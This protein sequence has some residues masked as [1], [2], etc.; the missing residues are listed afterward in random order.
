[1]NF[2]EI[3]TANAPEIEISKKYWM[4]FPEISPAYAPEIKISKKYWMSFPGFANKG[5]RTF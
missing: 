3:G 4:S 2:R 1:M 5:K